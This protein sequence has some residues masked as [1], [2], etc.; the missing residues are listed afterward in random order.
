MRA[1]PY[2]A[3]PKRKRRWFQFSLWKLLIIV[4]LL[5]VAWAV[6]ER[7]A[8]WMWEGLGRF[9]IDKTQFT[10]SEEAYLKERI[11]LPLP[12]G[13]RFDWGKLCH[14]FQSSD[15]VFSVRLS[16]DEADAFRQRVESSWVR[17]DGIYSEWLAWIFDGDETKPEL[18]AAFSL[19]DATLDGIVF[20]RSEGDKVPVLF[21]IAGFPRR[22]SRKL[23]GMF[24]Q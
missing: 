1:D 19:E 8:G 3:E 24:G 16:L 9:V 5:A 17:N 2:E 15:Y 22:D 23:Q 12:A 11:A 14:G 7:I 18:D 21:W 6:T 13:A 20:C 4:M 10:P